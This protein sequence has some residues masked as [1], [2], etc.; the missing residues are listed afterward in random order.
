MRR[1]SVTSRLLLLTLLALVPA[2]LVLT[3]NLFSARQSAYREIHSSALI[4]GHLASLEMRRIVSSIHSTLDVLSTV[5]ILRTGPGRPCSD[6]VRVV[7]E[8]LEMLE[9]I[10]VLSPTGELLCTSIPAPQ[11]NNF[12]DRQYFQDALSSRSFVL[13]TYIVDRITGDPTLPM[14]LPVLDQGEVRQVIVAYLDLE[15]LGVRVREREYSGGGNS[16]TIADRNG[17]I[18]AREPLP[19]RFVGTTIPE[20]F[21]HLVRQNAPGTVEITSQDGTKRILG[22][23]PDQEAF[24]VSAGY[25]VE[26]GLQQVSR[27]TR[28]GLVVIALAIVGPFFAVWW[29]GHALIRRPAHEIVRSIDAWRKGNESVRTGMTGDGA[30]GI[31]GSAV[32]AFMDELALR[33]EQQQ[34]DDRMRH[35]LIRELDHR[36]K[37]IL[38]MVQAV[39]RQTFR[40]ADS[41]EDVSEAF[42]RRLHAMA[43][44]HQLLTKNWQSASLKA[45]VETAIAPFE[46]PD[47]NRFAI[48]GE[49]FEVPSS[50]ALSLSMAL[51]ELCTNAAKYGALS[52]ETGRVEIKWTHP[53][54]PD[55]DFVFTWKENGGPPVA[56][57]KREGFGTLMI[58]RVLSQQLQAKVAMRY[59]PMG[60]Q[61]EIRAPSATMNA[62]VDAKPTGS[63]AK[64]HGAA[65]E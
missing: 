29:A 54:T 9:N 8:K 34:Q 12:S 10:A 21:R 4:T 63:A 36:I 55:S 25:S 57:P 40:A 5:P 27:V 7:D 32:D 15:W 1:M 39:A 48:E 65:A 19:E 56:P 41:V 45:T 24:Y 23:Y 22:Y 30:F 20:E 11:N 52:V 44:A 53:A 59:E 33:R 42:F 47:L 51:H 60:L 3:Y 17:V 61:C 64:E 43:G 18:I 2:L 6:Y 26:G 58:E 49:D 62:S 13:G 35:I 50:T 38:S 31:I 14:A 46:D 28:F 37:N 16:L